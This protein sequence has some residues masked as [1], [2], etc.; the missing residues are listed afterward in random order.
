LS[1]LPQFLNSRLEL[2]PGLIYCAKNYPENQKSQRKLRSLRKKLTPYAVFTIVFMH[3]AHR[4]LRTRRPL[5][6]TVTR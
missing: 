2:Q 5:T 4:T 3:L 1:P 6:I